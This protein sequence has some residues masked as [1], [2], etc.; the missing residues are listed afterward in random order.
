MVPMRE[1]LNFP[2]APPAAFA[3]LD[4]QLTGLVVNAL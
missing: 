4:T 3:Q 1:I 2:D